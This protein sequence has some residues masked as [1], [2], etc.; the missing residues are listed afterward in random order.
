M[1]RNK[2]FK[3]FHVEDSVTEKYKAYANL[4][5]IHSGNTEAEKGTKN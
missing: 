3:E 5:D 2:Y 1:I 4:P